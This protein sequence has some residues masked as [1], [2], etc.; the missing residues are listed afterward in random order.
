MTPADVDQIVAAFL[1]EAGAIVARISSSR[2]GHPQTHPFV[3]DADGTV[4]GTGLVTVNGTAAGSARS[5]SIRRG[6]AAASGWP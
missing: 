4:V 2:L 1:R 3:A 6:A 5:G